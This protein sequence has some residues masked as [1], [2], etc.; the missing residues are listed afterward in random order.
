[1]QGRRNYVRNVG[2]FI[3]ALI[4]FAALGAFPGFTMGSLMGQNLF[5]AFAAMFMSR[6]V[7]HYL[8]RWQFPPNVKALLLG[9]LSLSAFLCIPFFAIGFCGIHFAHFP[10][11]RIQ[12]LLG[13]FVIAFLSFT[14]GYAGN[15][16]HII[17]SLKESR[18][19]AKEE[20]S[21]S[22]SSSG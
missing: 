22:F 1:M 8:L 6:T 5:S 12:A 16:S 7:S 14:C 9:D 11:L 4:A 13:N 21:L 19:A 15:Q 10:V 2:F 20:F 3:A 17:S 18:E